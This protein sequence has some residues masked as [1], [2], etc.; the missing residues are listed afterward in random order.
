[1]NV[2]FYL[3]R[4]KSCGSTAICAHVYHMYA[5][6]KYYLPYRVKPS[7]WDIKN[8]RMLANGENSALFNE[9]LL[10]A[11]KKID[12]AL[13]GYISANDGKW[14]T[15]EKFRELLDEIFQR[16][17]VHKAHKVLGKFNIGNSRMIVIIQK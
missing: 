14:P 8:Q 12:D 15:L 2:M 7:E 17:R 9:L 3:K 10:C 6:Y 11:S 16:K 13:Q 5:T 4:S 1:M